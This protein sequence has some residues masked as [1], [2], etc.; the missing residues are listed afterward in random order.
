MVVGVLVVLW[1]LF[2]MGCFLSVECV[3]SCGW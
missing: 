3:N 2:G 1:F